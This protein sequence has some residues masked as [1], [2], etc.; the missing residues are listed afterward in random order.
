MCKDHHMKDN[1]QEILVY[2]TNEVYYVERNASNQ[3]K[4]KYGIWKTYLEQAINLDVQELR[5]E[6]Y[7][8]ASQLCDDKHDKY[9]VK[10][11]LVYI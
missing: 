1:T 2:T 3:M 9:N 11:A 6:Y 8:K 4:E 5:V 7:S 10:S